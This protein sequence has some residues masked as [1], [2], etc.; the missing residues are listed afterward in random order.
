MDRGRS[1]HMISNL[2]NSSHLQM[3]NFESIPY[4]YDHLIIFIW[5]S[6]ISGGAL[7]C[8][9]G[10]CKWLRF[11]PFLAVYQVL[12]FAPILGIAVH[13]LLP[14]SWR[15]SMYYYS[16]ILD[17]FNSLLSPLSAPPLGQCCLTRPTFEQLP[18]HNLLGAPSTVRFSEFDSRLFFHKKTTGTSQEFNA[19]SHRISFT[20]CAHF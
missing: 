12:V 15:H 5:Y 8:Q 19:W 13:S 4:E 14:N 9:A 6:P 1:R 17:V 7:G 18:L 3:S 16:I 11:S 2:S 20:T 10:I